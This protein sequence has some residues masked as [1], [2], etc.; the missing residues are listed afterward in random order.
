MEDQLVQLLSNTQLSEQ[1]PRLQAELELKRART[2]PAFPLSLANIAAHTSIDTN[3]RQAALSNLRLF[4]ENNW[5][6]DDPDDGP[7]IP[8][9]DEA[10]GQL[11]QVLLD[12][13]LSPEDDRKVKISA[14]YAVGKI[15]VHDFPEQWPN[16]LPTVISVVPA[17]TDS[18]LHGA[19]RLLNDIIEE[20]LSEDQFFSMAQDIAKALA[21]VALNENRKPMH[22][23]LAISIFRGCF[24]LLNM[25]KEDH[26]KE[27]RAFAD[28]LLQQWNPFFI[29]VLQSPLPEA[30]LESGSQPDSWSHIIALKLQVVKTLLRIRRVFPNL[31]L[32]QSTIFFSAV[33]KELSTLQGPHEQLYIK[34]DAQGRLEDSDNLPYTLDFLI[35]EE[36]DFLNQCFRAPPVQAELDGHLNAHASAQDVPWMKEIMNM[37]IG[38]SRVTREEEDL[39]DIDCSLY[40]A[41]E[42]SVTA[43]YTARTAAGDLLIK[44][45]E[46]FNQKTIDGLFGQT[47]SLFGGEGSD[48]RSQE[49]A[50]YLFVMLVSDFQDMNKDIPEAVAHAYLSLVD[51]A[52]NRPGEPLLRARGYLVAG[53]LCRSFQTPVELLDRIITSITQ[54]ESEVVQVACV[55]AV[56]GLINAGRVSADRQVPIIN[57]IQN[58]MNN[59]DPS[60]MEDADELL[61]TLAEAL[62]AAITLDKRIALSNDVKSVDLLFMLAKL[63]ASN[64]QVTM[65]ISEAFEDIVAD[66]SDTES[67]TALCAKLLPTLTGAFDVANLTEDN[68][69]VTVS[70]LMK[71]FSCLTDN[72][73]VATELLAVL[74][75]N[76]PE[77]LPA[78]FVA[79]TFPKLN[80]LLMESTE[81]EVLRPGSEVVKWMLQHDHQQVLAWQDANGRSGLEVCLHIID[82][83]LGPSIEDNSASEVG[84][85]A[86]ELVEKAGQERLG[87]FLPQL[88]QAVANRLATAQAA[89]FIQSLIL[90]FARLTLSGA[91]DVVEFLSQVQINGES[92]LQVVMAKWL[93]N[94]V[95]FAGYDEIRQNVIALSKLYS[96]NDPRLAQ[97][98]VKGDLIVNN[99]DGLIKTRSRAKQNPDQY[100][101]V[102]ASLKIIKVLIEELL[103][104]S[105]QRAAANAASAAVASA[106][107]DDEN[108]EEGWEDED[109]TLDLSLGTTKADLMSF[110]EGGQRQRDDE[111]QAYLTDFF[112]RCGRENIANFQE[113]YNML[114]EEEK[115]KLNEVASSAGQ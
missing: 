46:W 61:V 96:L 6:N 71:Q 99:D 60:D 30:N 5:S 85:L 101:I 81:G 23:A 3:I 20:S 29:T 104:A 38:Y 57:A 83:L 88:L 109:D 68:P 24:D 25:I 84:G 17:G 22:R 54:E 45:G 53:M 92:G 75:E 36:L 82:R 19:L 4:I 107:F 50:L 34:E 111:T 74:A 113:W 14:S 40:L 49:A 69:L 108:D 79:A 2:N 37:L 55:K 76:G 16:L 89:A 70:I 27:V 28:G 114:T 42:T 35:L 115:S 72:T 48:W 100:T 9:S 78:G 18:Q 106:S 15:A 97:T 52:V 86:A 21:E 41:E 1:G 26:A 80:R 66:L 43:N 47:Q 95:N 77:P 59:K 12:L 13:V 93:E 87:P 56:E 58:Y 39:W 73:Q 112:I 94:S 11:K 10:R 31:L 44:M 98:Q 110:M 65:L 63:G 62:R 33:W 64:F 51:Y 90:V 105:G 32:P 103:S 7:I 8:I 91:Q 102:P 67:Y